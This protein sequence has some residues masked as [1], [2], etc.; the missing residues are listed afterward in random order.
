MGRRRINENFGQTRTCKRR[1]IEIFLS[2][3]AQ[4]ECFYSSVTL[5]NSL[6]TMFPPIF[7]RHHFE[8]ARIRRYKRSPTSVH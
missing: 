1:G 5:R 4:Y 3:F 6:L 2:R 7:R 8:T